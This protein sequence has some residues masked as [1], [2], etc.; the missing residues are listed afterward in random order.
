MITTITIGAISINSSYTSLKEEAEKSLQLLSIDGAKVTESRMNGLLATLKVISMEKDIINMGFE[1]NVNILKEGLGKTDFLD[2]GYVLPNGYTH[3]TDGT[4]RLM[5]DRLYVQE[6]LAGKSMI[7]DV[8][9]S[10]V[11]RTSEIEFCVPV[12]KNGEVVGAL[13]ARSAADS[14]S[15]IITDGGYGENG[16]A[17][18][19]NGEG[20]LIAHPDTEKITDRF[21]PIKES[22]KNPIYTSLANAF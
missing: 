22:E 5:S 21:N 15:N 1:V 17:Y 18:M 3:F 9:I 7:S 12:L 11:T 20:N 8:I 4:V 19:I 16:Y 14:L 6:A 10:R 2:I 13:L